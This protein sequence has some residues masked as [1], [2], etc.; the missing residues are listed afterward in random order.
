MIPFG[1]SPQQFSDRYHRCLDKSTLTTIQ[2]L[3]ALFA[4]PVPPDVASARVEIFMGESG[5]ETPSVWIYYSGENNKVDN[6]IN[7]HVSTI[8][9]GRAMDLALNL[10]IDGFHEKYYA[11]DD[12]QKNSIGLIA[13]LVK[14][15]FAQCWWKAGGWDYQVPAAVWVHDAFDGGTCT[16]LTYKISKNK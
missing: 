13:N 6:Q 2:T 10:E 5:N 1:L 12:Y 8:S 4:M 15:W 11:G 3:K 7:N 16:E 9:A 14:T